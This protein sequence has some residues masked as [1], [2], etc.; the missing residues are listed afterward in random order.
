MPVS[1]FLVIANS[2]PTADGRNIKESWLKDIAGHYSKDFYTANLFQSH[3]YRG[4]NL[5]CIEEVKL[6]EV[7]HGEF[8][9]RLAL[10]AKL[11]GNAFLEDW[12]ESGEKLY[13]SIEVEEEFSGS[14][15]AYMPAVVVTREPASVGCDDLK[16]SQRKGVFRTDAI[17]IE[18]MKFSKKKPNLA[19]RFFNKQPKE[20]HEMKPEQF[21]AIKDT[22]GTLTEA[23]NSMNSTISALPKS[24]VKPDTNPADTPNNFEKQV[25]E[26]EAANKQLEA[27]NKELEQ[28]YQNAFAR[29]EKL[30]KL[31]GEE[32]DGTNTP[33]EGG[34]DFNECL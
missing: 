32:Q 33:P 14:D 20:D 25:S 29:I 3:Y 5:G 15:K 23:V 19:E 21:S 28:N 17:E 11:N 30:E 6:E 7:D 22:L 16:F 24:E 31:A 1:D 26:L 9:K 34:N 12:A 10:Y 18:P 4:F 2:G 27:K 8:G 13:C